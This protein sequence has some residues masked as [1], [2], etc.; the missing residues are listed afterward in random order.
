MKKITSIRIQLNKPLTIRETLGLH[1]ID[2][3][4]NC[5]LYVL[6]DH[7]KVCLKQL[8]K[9]VVFSLTC[10]K[11]KPITIIVEGKDPS[12]VVI[13]IQKLLEPIATTIPF[14]VS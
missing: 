2:K 14:Q 4:S 11:N 9:L 7:H 13:G 10:T 5:N 3:H 12:T 8:S 1:T 6:Y